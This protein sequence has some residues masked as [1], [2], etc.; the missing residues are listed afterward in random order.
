MARF[1]GGYKDPNYLRIV[2]KIERRG[3]N[4]F[5]NQDFIDYLRTDECARVMENDDITIHVE[6]GEYLVGEI[7]TGESIYN[8]LPLQMDENKKVIKTALRYAGPLKGFTDDYLLSAI[9]TE[10]KW[11]LDSDEFVY[12]KCLVANYNSGYL[13]M[14]DR[15]PIYCRHSRATE[16]DLMLESMNQNNWHDFLDNAMEGAMTNRKR[17]GNE[18]ADNIFEYLRICFHDYRV[19][20]EDIALAYYVLLLTSSQKNII[21]VLKFIDVPLRNVKQFVEVVGAQPHVG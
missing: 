14:R 19:I 17:S 6:S 2:N 9:G 13:V 5:D 10:E 4:S 18:N 16:D 12:L 8:F 3:L 20:F 1:A 11:M 7:E 21:R 15:E